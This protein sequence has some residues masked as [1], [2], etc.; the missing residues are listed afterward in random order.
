MGLV[1]V[2]VD[3]AFGRLGVEVAIHLERS[4][5]FL[6]VWMMC[7]VGLKVFQFFLQMVRFGGFAVLLRLLQR[8]GELGDVGVDVLQNACSGDC[9]QLRATRFDSIPP[10]GDISF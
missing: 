6:L 2:V 3:Q 10:Y 4:W 1:S 5:V 9:I 7:F 8:C